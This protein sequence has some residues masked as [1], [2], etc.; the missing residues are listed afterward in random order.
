MNI[1][2]SN[3]LKE[4]SRKIYPSL[5]GTFS[6]SASSFVE[7]VYPVYA[8]YG[9]GSKFVDV[10]GNEYLDFLCGLGPITL[11]YNY[12]PVNEA[13]EEQLRKGVLF[14]LPHPIELEL[15]EIGRIRHAKK[16]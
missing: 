14:S 3:E 7:G 1:K 6:R 16:I 8:E 12:K 10:D 2:K 13:A 9:N 11:G 15:S 4:R 5:T